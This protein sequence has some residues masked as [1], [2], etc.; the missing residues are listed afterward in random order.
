M[1][2]IEAVTWSCSGPGSA[3]SAGTAQNTVFRMIIGGSTGFS[4]MIAFP[5]A[6]PP[7]RSRAVAV[8]WVNSSM[9]ARVPGPA[10]R[11]ATDD[12]ISAYG[13]GTTADTAATIGTVA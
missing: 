11:D 2:W 12:T 6:A 5:R 7:I 8:V 1:A 3:A 9:F 10:D 13:T 4:R